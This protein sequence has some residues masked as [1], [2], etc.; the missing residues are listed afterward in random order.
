MAGSVEVRQGVAC[1]GKQGMGLGNG[2][3]MQL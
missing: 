3:G 1:S 2:R